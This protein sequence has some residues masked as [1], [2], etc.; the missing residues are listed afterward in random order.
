MAEPGGPFHLLQAGPGRF[1]CYCRPGGAVYVTDAMEVWAGDLSDCPALE[2]RCPAE[3]HGAMLRGLGRF[4]SSSSL[5]GSAERR[6]SLSLAGQDWRALCCIG[7][8]CHKLWLWPLSQQRWRHWH[9]PAALRRTL[10]GA[11]SSC[12]QTLA[13]GRTGLLAQLCLTRG[14]SQESLS[15]TLVSKARR[16]H[17]E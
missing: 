11:S 10:S 17:L 6:T 13:P 3:E 2:C 4:W 12:C 16:H 15:S 5:D 7:L 9:L 1:L 8:C 14:R